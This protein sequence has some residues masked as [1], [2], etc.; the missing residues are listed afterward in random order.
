[1][2]EKLLQISLKVNRKYCLFHILVPY[3]VNI[4]RL[5][6]EETSIKL[7]DWLQ[8]CSILRPLEF[9]SLAEIKNRLKYVKDYKPISF[10]KLN[11][12]NWELYP[13]LKLCGI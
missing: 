12:M 3:L 2:T 10:S 11:D 5:S 9:D 7:S 1:M 4:K 6:T 8:G 13:E